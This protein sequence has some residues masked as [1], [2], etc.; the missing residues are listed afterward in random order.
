MYSVN[1]SIIVH[2]IVLTSGKW[3]KTKYDRFFCHYLKH[4]KFIDRVTGL[5]EKQGLTKAEL[6]HVN[7][8]EVIGA[9]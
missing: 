4:K 8:W 3:Y 7:K 2:V 6:L 1:Y 5:K 9:Q